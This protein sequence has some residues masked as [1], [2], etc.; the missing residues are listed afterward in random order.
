MLEFLLFILIAVAVSFFKAYKKTGSFNR[1]IEYLKNKNSS[2]AK[3]DHEEI[4]TFEKEDDQIE[5]CNVTTVNRDL[6]KNEIKYLS[7]N[8]RF[9][10]SLF[11]TGSLINLS[12]NLDREIYIPMFN[13]TIY[14]WYFSLF[15]LL[16]S[17]FTFFKTDT[18]AKK[19]KIIL[20]EGKAEILSASNIVHLRE[21]AISIPKHWF[22]K[23]GDRVS[24]EGYESYTGNVTALNMGYN[25]VDSS[26]IK[27]RGKWVILS[28]FLFINLFIS[29]LVYEGGWSLNKLLAVNSISSES[30]IA[31]SYDSLVSK[32]FTKGQYIQIQNIDSI[33]VNDTLR[34][35]RILLPN[36]NTFNL[37]LSDIYYRLEKL[38]ELQGTLMFNTLKYYYM[39][40]I[41][42]SFSK[43][44]QKSDFT[45]FLE[46]DYFLD[47]LDQW[48]GYLNNELWVD[49]SQAE[50]D[51]DSFIGSQVD[52]IKSQLNS[53]IDETIHSNNFIKLYPTTADYSFD[54]VKE[55]LY[56]KY[57]NEPFKPKYHLDAYSYIKEIEE[58]F[59]Q[60]EKV[61][62]KF[63]FT[64]YIDGEQSTHIKIDIIE[65]DRELLLIY[66]RAGIFVLSLF[67]YIFVIGSS[68]RIKKSNNKLRDF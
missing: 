25:S 34:R 44:F 18:K 7:T 38:K 11:I 48:N 55:Q 45:L 8:I 63:F 5:D 30:I 59:K 20:I 68:I 15:I 22:V 2:T 26:N 49:I 61:T 36:N 51:L 58:Q 3:D 66:Y 28:L 42:F 65:T 9:L 16:I 52:I 53:A 54:M 12:I 37:D 13:L 64:S 50:I 47:A 19:G 40:D 41:D 35:Y 24:I 33:I 46:N 32:S 39:D 31:T 67:L 27:K 14:T 23:D 57:F 1:A 4:S 56:I 17:M 6:T 43:N 62:M 29:G 21:Y 60:S 10:S